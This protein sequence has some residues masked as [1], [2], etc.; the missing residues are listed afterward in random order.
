ML[1]CEL[2]YASNVSH[3]EEDTQNSDPPQGA[4]YF[5]FAL[6]IVLLAVSMFQYPLW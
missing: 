2:L 1:K 3:M 4:Y 5:V 6:S